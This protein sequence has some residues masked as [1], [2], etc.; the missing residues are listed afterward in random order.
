MKNILAQETT[1]KHLPVFPLPVF[2]LPKG[3]ARLRIF[4]PKYLTMLSLI[5]NHQCFVIQLTP[6]LPEMEGS[7]WGSLV[8]IQDFNQGDDGILEIDVLCNSLVHLSHVKQEEND[9]NYAQISPFTH[10]SQSKVDESM[11]YEVLAEALNSILDNNVMLN[12]LYQTRPLN[13]AHWV[14]ARWIELLPLSITVKNLFVQ[15]DSFSSAKSF[16]DSI[17]HQ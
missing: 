14:V 4:E 2:I 17:I 13:N 11:A 16:V 7:N 10:W 3:K 9:L 8:K 15:A 5:S 1:P 12:E 6:S